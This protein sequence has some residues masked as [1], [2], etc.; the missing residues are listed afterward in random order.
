VI[1]IIRLTLDSTLLGQLGKRK[2]RLVALGVTPSNARKVWKSSRT[3]PRGIRAVLE[4]MA[5]GIQRCMYCGDNLGTDI[6]HFDPMR[7]SPIKTFEWTN[8]FLSC[9]HCNSNE[10]RDEYPCDSSGD[11]L[12]VDPTRDD[13]LDHIRLILNEGKYE[14]LTPKGSE[15]IRVFGLNRPDLIR[16]RENAFR[17]RS[18]ILAYVEILLNQGRD[19]EAQDQMQVLVE[20]PHASVF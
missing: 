7:N 19:A 13:P 17:A 16:A 5:P 20:E 15:T 4:L 6:D 11:C 1:P 14:P 3:A 9:S 18:A 12:L 8:H 10:K 2:A